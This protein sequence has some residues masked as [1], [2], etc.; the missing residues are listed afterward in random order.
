MCVIDVCE[1]RICRGGKPTLKNIVIAF[2]QMH[3]LL[4]IMSI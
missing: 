2:M 3:S 1:G 4:I